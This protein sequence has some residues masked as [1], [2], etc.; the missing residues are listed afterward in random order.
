MRFAFKTAYDQDLGL[1]RDP[2]QRRWYAGLLAAVLLLL[3]FWPALF[4]P[5]FAVAYAAS[6]PLL[7]LFGRFSGPS[8]VETTHRPPAE[9]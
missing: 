8:R 5:G 3:A 7:W 9:P 6:G 4:F 2:V 1:F